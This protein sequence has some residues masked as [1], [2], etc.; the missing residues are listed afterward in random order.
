M[1]Y[2]YFFDL[3]TAPTLNYCHKSW[4]L[5]PTMGQAWRSIP[6]WPP[7]STH[8][9]ARAFSASA[10]QDQR[11]PDSRRSMTPLQLAVIPRWSTTPLQ[12]IATPWRLA[13]TPRRL[14]ATP[15]RVSTVTSCHGQHRFGSTITSMTQQ[16]HYQHDLVVTSCHGQHRLNSVITSTTKQH[17]HQHDL[18]TTLRH[19]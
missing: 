18:A 3:T 13:T 12:S 2:H 4:Q 11:H 1:Y 19:G 5:M 6:R 17:R 14:M 9:I 8:L 7:W 15:W 16:H 10:L